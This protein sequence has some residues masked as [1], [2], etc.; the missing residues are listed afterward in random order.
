M[1]PRS[2]QAA[3]QEAL[4][5]AGP[6]ERSAIARELRGPII[7]KNASDLDGI[8]QLASLQHL[9][10]FGCDVTTVDALAGL[11]ELRTL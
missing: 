5:E 6:E 9:A 2:F 4:A 10:L 11:P 8:G 7:V 3:L 1:K